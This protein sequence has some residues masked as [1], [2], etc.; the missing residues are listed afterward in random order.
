MT[1]AGGS[2]DVAALADMTAIE[3]L[4]PE[5]EA[6]E[7]RTPEATGFQSFAWSRRWLREAEKRGAP[8]APRVVTV[9]ENGR[10]AML[11]PLQI[12]RRLGAAIACWIGEPMTQY[13]DIL[14]EAGQGRARWRAAAEA[15]MARWRDVDLFA[16]ARLRADGVLAA[17]EAGVHEGEGLVAPYLDF[18][19]G[20]DWRR[21]RRSLE[22]R[23]RKLA[24]HGPPQFDEVLDPAL[25]ES[26]TRRALALK[27][28]W[29]DAKGLMSA[30]LSNPVTE[31]FLAGLARD[32]FLRVHR[33]RVGEQ[34]AAIDLGILG[35]GAYRSLIGCY[36]MRFADGSPGQALTA[37]LVEHCAGQGMARFD[38]LAPA[39]AYKFSWSNGTARMGARFRPTTL[40][41]RAAAFAL[42]R[43]RP[44]AKRLLRPP[45]AAARAQPRAISPFQ[46]D[47]L[48]FPLDPLIGT[49]GMIVRSCKIF[50]VASVGILALLIGVNNI[51][52]YGPNYEVVQHI[53]AM[54][55]IPPG[56]ALMWRAVTSP[57][58]HHLLYWF[59]IAAELAAGALCLVG[60]H[61]LWRALRADAWSFHAAKDVATLGLVTAFSL[62]FLGFMAVGG[63]WFQM[64][65]SNGFNEQEPAF[66]FIG[67]VGLVLLFLGQREE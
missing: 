34:V 62:Y 27:R 16:F 66:R 36:D 24:A 10:L 41:G 20:G 18:S 7:A 42:A 40:R 31:D 43:L 58:L 67:S 3:R 46:D 11:W 49:G 47:A 12:E 4:A 53:M 6:L 48:S 38:L 39:D 64:W 8:L 63:E 2:L 65:R 15:E 33:L 37:R 29:L 56:S 54:D 44:L 13:G 25:R 32:G 22:R 51:F 1:E 14:A 17:D 9:R 5:W 61:R 30:G 28:A 45:T 57:A 50:L 35:G 55:T 23:A 52:D 21:R 59:I 60:A 19:A 26:L